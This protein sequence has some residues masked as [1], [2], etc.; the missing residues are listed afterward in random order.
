MSKFT[1][2]FNNF[3]KNPLLLKLFFALLFIFF[4]TVI[5][6]ISFIVSYNYEDRYI[7]TEMHKEA[8]A[9]MERKINYLKYNIDKNKQYL[10]SISNNNIFKGYI[11]NQNEKKNV[12]SLFEQ[13]I[14][15][16]NDIM[17]VRYIDENGMENI[18]LERNEK[19]KNYH[20]VE[21][22]SLQNKKNRY[23]FQQTSTLPENSPIWISDIDL[24]VENGKVVKPY[25]PT[26]RFVKTIFDNN[27]FKGI[28]ILNIFMKDI[29]NT[30]AQSD[31]YLVSIMDMNGDFLIGKYELNSQV[32]DFSWSKYIL[33]KVNIE[34]FLSD[35]TTSILR[36]YHYDTEYLHSKKIHKEVGIDQ[37]LA[38][39]LKIKDKKIQEVK[40]NTFHKVLDT[41]AFVLLISGPI[42]LILAYIPSLLSTR[43][44]ESSKKLD[45][46]TIIFNEYLEA[47]NVNNIISKSDLKGNITYVNKNFCD[48][49]GYTEEEVIGQP[50]SLLRSDDE[51][52][53][54]FKILWLTIQAKKVW[55]G[56]L[57]NKKKDGGY[58]DVDIAIMPI[59][60]QEGAIIEYL[61]IRHEITELIEQ[62][63]NLTTIATQDPL[64]I[65]GNRYKLNLDINQHIVNNIAVIDIDKF[66]QINDFYGHK[67]G[68]EVIIKFSKLLQENLT[69]EFE[70]Y[71]LHSDKFAIHNYTLS[72][73]RFT[74]FIIHLN[75]K[76]IESVIETDV[77][78]FDI[79]TTSGISSCDKDVILSTAEM[80]NK[81]AKNISKK[82]LSYS[83]DLRIE[84]KFEN[85][86][87]WTEKVKKALNEN[88]IITFYQ[89]IYNNVTNQIEK[90]ETLVRLKDTDGSIISPF[91]FLDIAKSSGQYIEITKIVIQ[92]SFEKFKDLDIEFSIN[93]TIEDIL[94]DEVSLYLEN[95]LS[96]YK[97]AHKVVL[98]LV[99]SEGIE[100]FETVQKFIQKVKFLGCKV[101]I[102]DFG[103]GYSN[104]EYLAKLQADYIK[105]DGS[106]IKNI[107]N[108]ENMKEIVKTI[109]NF[110]KKM[111]YKTIAEFVA[112]EEISNTIKELQIDYSQ[113][114]YIGVPQEELL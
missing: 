28:I 100:E 4:A 113:G 60:N 76:M 96:E 65:V 9:L 34:K 80:V 58:Y 78:S 41:M 83:P 46:K 61:A 40:E 14:S 21:D 31:H 52:K 19:Y 88:R 72:S 22:S 11:E 30:I 91:Y 1:F 101:A 15:S 32:F 95:M 93:L 47:M 2:S 112:T 24:N 109:I 63:K 42:G 62:R 13:I 66:S 67:L 48:V 69:N 53:E 44:L 27:E 17:Q 20:I 75:A 59:M 104:F 98:E 103:T 73:D 110:S 55:Q 114:Y 102:D 3:L 82:V 108:D 94:D 8:T 107:N 7:K 33:D 97:I 38:L 10:Y 86:I 70:L 6:A 23:Y 37:E 45:E 84:E 64:C 81:Y 36:S 92:K 50:H 79:V 74:N 5:A 85:N 71:R 68:D 99:E 106:M 49:S 77:K 111:D 39:V 16:D 105:I 57:R 56:I 87:K 18:R 89:P 26:L 12:I 25:M 43:V 29:L 90:Y 54:T 35:Y 51:P